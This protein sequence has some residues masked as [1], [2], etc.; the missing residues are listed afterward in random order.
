MKRPEK[1]EVTGGEFAT[2]FSD[3][4]FVR[5][6]THLF[7]FLA[8]TKWDDGGARE[9]ATLLL[10]FDAGRL[11]GALKDRAASRVAFV[12][13]DSVAGLLMTLERGLGEDSLE[14]RPESKWK[15]KGR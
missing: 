8:D 2:L 7:H 14:W 3:D 5:V 6:Y 11:K 9:T 1:T 4:E 13:A 15:G 10:F 12:T